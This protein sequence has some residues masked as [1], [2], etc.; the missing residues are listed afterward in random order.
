MMLMRNQFKEALFFQK[1][2]SRRHSFFKKNSRRH[3]FFKINSR[4]HSIMEFIED[5]CVTGHLMSS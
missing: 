1:K 4:R 5:T 2:N 3:S